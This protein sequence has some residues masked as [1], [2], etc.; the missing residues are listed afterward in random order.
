MFAY[1]VWLYFY[2][3]TRYASAIYI[4]LSSC[5]C[6]SVRYKSHYKMCSVA[7]RKILRSHGCMACVTMPWM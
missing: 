5:V 6:Q 3:T 1:I 7:P 4:M 2:R